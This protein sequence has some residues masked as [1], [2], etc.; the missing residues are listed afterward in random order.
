MNDLIIQS[1]T[2]V[3]IEQPLALPGVLITNRRGNIADAR[4]P[5]S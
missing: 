4:I 3:F 5:L 2:T 1:I